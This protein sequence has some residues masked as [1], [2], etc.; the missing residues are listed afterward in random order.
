[1]TIRRPF[2][3]TGID[4]TR[5]GRRDLLKLFGASALVALSVPPTV[6]QALAAPI[7][8][9]YPFQ[10]GVAA[11]DPAPDGFVIWTRL[12]PLPLEPGYG[13]PMQPVEVEWQVAEDT[14]FRTVAQQGTVVAR[15]ELGHACHVEVAGLQPGRTYFYRFTAGDERSIVG[16][17]RTLP[18]AGAMPEQIRFAVAGCQSYEQGYYTAF[19]D[20]ALQDELD[21]VF[22]YGDY[23]YEYDP[24][25]FTFDRHL[26]RQ[27]PIVRDVPGTEIMTLDD[28]RRR[29][30]VYKMD[31]DLQLAHAAAAFIPTW[32]DH[33]IDNNWAANI[34]QDG[35]P[36]EVFDLRRVAAAQAYYEN[37]PLRRTS[38][39]LGPA[40]RLYRRFEAGGLMSFSALDTRQYR[41]DQP[42]GDGVKAICPDIDDPKATMLGAEQEK[43]LF[44]GLAR[45][46]ARWNTIGQQVVVMAKDFG[47]A[48]GETRNLDA[49][50]G[51]R[52]PRQRLMDHL[53]DRK[54][55]NTVILTGDMHQNVAGDLHRRPDDPASPIV[56]SEFVATSISSGF[57][58]GEARSTYPTV[59]SRNPHIKFMNDQRGYML[60]TVRQDR[61]EAAFRVVDRVRTPDG[62]VS[63]RA[64]LV[65]EA[66]APGLKTA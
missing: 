7:F 66:D 62:T 49:W 39:P 50:D 60:H 57:D 40:I 4:A 12:A 27:V 8:V 16:R 20:L 35:V 13:M 30:A 56:A 10:L 3:G 43:W 21:F 46:K 61:W 64:T 15:P 45:S 6:R 11:G 9:T 24:R 19:R 47:R 18:A 38:W 17:A 54:I 55:R 41:S 28:Y 63:T 25:P 31:P 36:P 42:C 5:L 58:G 51:Y 59:L 23:I 52:V 33:E 1:M 26:N 44:E 22:H 34:A 48:D 37:M 65:V 32:D 53:H 2:P 14:G 29:Y